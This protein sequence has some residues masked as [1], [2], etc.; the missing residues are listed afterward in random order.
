MYEKLRI[1]SAKKR[2]T[3]NDNERQ[4]TSAEPPNGN[5]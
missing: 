4:R 2:T 5:L 1:W 3:T